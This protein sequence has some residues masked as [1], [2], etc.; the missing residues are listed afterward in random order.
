MNRFLVF[1]AA[2]MAAWPAFSAPRVSGPSEQRGSK[3]YT[4]TFRISD[5][6]DSEAIPVSGFCAVRYSQ[7]SGDDAS[8]YAI[9]TAT[10]AASSGTLIASFTASTTTPTTFS[11]GTLWV[12]AVATDATA[13]GSTMTI[14]CHPM[15][16]AGGVD[17]YA[18][19]GANMTWQT[20]E[21][22]RSMT[23]F[24]GLDPTI[25]WT[26]YW[27]DPYS[28]SDSNQGTYDKPFKTL[29]KWKS[30]ANF[31]TWFTIKNGGRPTTMYLSNQ[32]FPYTITSGTCNIG[33]QISHNTTHDSKILDIDYDNRIMVVESLTATRLA[34]S[35]AFTGDESGC[36]WTTGTRAPAIWDTTLAVCSTNNLDTCLVANRGTATGCDAGTCYAASAVQIALPA[37]VPARYDGRIVSILD[38]EDPSNRP[39]IHGDK[40]SLG[41]LDNTGL[42]TNNERQGIFV[43]GGTGYGCLGVANIRTDAVIDDAISQHSEGCVKALN[44][45]SDR[46]WNTSNA[47]QNNIVTTHAGTLGRGGVVSINGGGTGYPYVET[48]GPPVAPTAGGDNGAF[49]IL[50][51]GDYVVDGTNQSN[52]NGLSIM[53]GTGGRNTLLNVDGWCRNLPGGTSGCQSW[54]IQSADG[55]T[56]F[57]AIR[58]VGRSSTNEFGAGFSL[59]AASGNSLTSKIYRPSFRGEVAARGIFT[60]ASSGPINIDVRGALFSAMDFYFYDLSSTLSNLSGSISGVYDNVAAD[61]TWHFGNAGSDYLTAAAAAAGSGVDILVM[62]D[63]ASIQTDATEYTTDFGARCASTGECFDAYTEAWSVAFPEIIYDYLPVPIYGYSE[64]GSR[65]YGAR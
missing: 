11:A 37:A 5:T 60:N 51:N 21:Y 55:D 27:I 3:S 23:R 49:M 25:P 61:N 1:L 59:N 4:V 6:A 24:E 35:T 8:L 18:M 46:V 58:T 57:D 44:V 26:R 42:A 12:K 28:G 65:S 20:V 22:M 45:T 38:S 7:A 13:G 29:G 40:R 39:I 50:V 47:T 17:S 43:T 48:S 41:D 2:A 34:S 36:S 62:E 16:A 31:G 56:T 64:A 15:S 10:T 14:E 63:A 53:S 54:S 19:S 30:M 52:T 9:P 33:E 32:T